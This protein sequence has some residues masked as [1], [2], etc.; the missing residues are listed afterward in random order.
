MFFIVKDPVHEQTHVVFQLFVQA[1]Y[2]HIFSFP[3][4]GLKKLTLQL[5]CADNLI[6]F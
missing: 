2:P 4:T 1:H 3:V 5:F 6:S